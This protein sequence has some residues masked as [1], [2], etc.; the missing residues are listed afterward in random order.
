[1]PDANEEQARSAAPEEPSPDRGLPSGPTGWLVSAIAVAGV[2][3]C[4]AIFFVVTHLYRTV[5]IGNDNLGL[6]LPV[7]FL[8]SSTI[9]DGAFPL[10]DPFSGTGASLLSIYTPTAASPLVL[11]LAFVR[12]YDFASFVTEILV[13]D[14]LAL[15]GMYLWVRSRGPRWIAATAAI[16][17]ALAPYFILQAQLNIE[18]VGT[19]AAIPWI[20]LGATR[21]AQGRVNGIPLLAGGLGLM[22]TSGYLGLNIL[23]I[24]FLVFGGVVWGVIRRA[25]Q[26]RSQRIHGLASPSIH[27][28]GTSIV[29][30]LLYAVSALALFGCM[31][32][33]VI[34]ETF[35]NTTLA[36]FT[37]RSIDPFV[38]AIQLD[39]LRTVL[40]TIG[41]NPLIGDA[42]G[43]HPALLFLPTATLLGLA[44][45]FWKPTP[46]FLA[47]VVTGTLV[48]FASLSQEHAIAR[49][50]VDIIPGLES[51]RFHGW[52]T[53]VIIFFFI[54]AGSEGLRRGVTGEPRNN[55]IVLA[56]G[57]A[58]SLAS[59]VAVIATGHWRFGLIV[60]GF[61][62]I[63][64]SIMIAMLGQPRA[65]RTRAVL[66][67][68]IA[69][70]VGAQV[71]LADGRIQQPSQLSA[72]ASA[73]IRELVDN[74]TTGF[75]R[76][77]PTRARESTM[78][79][80]YY[81]KAPV[82]ESYMP[83]RNPAISALIEAGNAERLR[84]YVLAR[85]G[86]PIA[87]SVL[88]LTPNQLR[89][90][91]PEKNPDNG[92]IFTTPYSPNWSASSGNTQLTTRKTAD[93]LMEVTGAHGRQDITLAYAPWYRWPLGILGV[94]AWL[95]VLG[96]PLWT[97][98][99]R[100]LARRRLA[101]PAS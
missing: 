17:Y 25:S 72:S 26:P 48:F 3:A 77:S 88:S 4:L 2:S 23:S 36:F 56:I 16:T 98:A 19:G 78:N 42:F 35:S 31:T 83:Q 8:I 15:W 52:L 65:F 69:G 1:M 84:P 70:M 9:Q 45:G 66:A 44:L 37:D 6:G 33:L 60:L 82:V 62:G 61:G 13:L 30:R 10:W 89:V 92:V 68:T 67:V 40:D 20:A 50:L 81:L 90:R 94:L 63:A 27:V 85:S 39:S 95:A 21:I 28:Q 57:V 49:W 38:A 75:P 7:R 76:P 80:H 96:W 91:L 24:E 71:A 43:A 74:A 41:V 51:I 97:Y 73:S 11:I 87:Y 32:G 46:L 53:G 99:Y 22:A 101:N 58:I 93:G 86:Q 55:R 18:A 12:H 34:A 64:L 5:P 59:G 54:T 29:R 100:H 14:A 47:S 79:A